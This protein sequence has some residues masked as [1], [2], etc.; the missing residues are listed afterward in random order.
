MI[1]QLINKGFKD[2]DQKIILTGLDLFTSANKNGVGKSAV[3]ESFKLALIGDLPGT[4]YRVEDILEFT[5]REEFS[6]ALLADIGGK[7]YRFERRFV[8]SAPQGDKRPIIVDG[9]SKKFE[10]GS[11]W[12]RNTFGALSLSFD[13]GE[14]LNL[15]DSKKRAW[16]LS[17][18]PE[19]CELSRDALYTLLLARITEAQFGPGLVTSILNRNG[20]E[21]TADLLQGTTKFSPTSVFSDLIISLEQQDYKFLDRIQKLLTDLFALW[22]EGEPPVSNLSALTT[23]LKSRGLE[24]KARLREQEAALSFVTHS[25][26]GEMESQQAVRGLQERL[27]RVHQREQELRF[28]KDTSDYRNQQRLSCQ[29]LMVSTDSAIKECE[30]IL[31]MLDPQALKNQIDGLIHDLQDLDPLESRLENLREAL[32]RQ[33]EP[34]T[35]LEKEN[36]RLQS[37]QQWKARGIRSLQQSASKCPLSIDVPCATDWTLYK[38]K[39]QEGL[40]QESQEQ[41][42][43]QEDL[44]ANRRHLWKIGGEIKVAQ[45][46]L[47][48]ARLAN[49]TIH[50]Q[51][52]QLTHQWMEEKTRKEEVESRLKSQQQ[53]LQ[54]A[55]ANLGNDPCPGPVND[56]SMITTQL[57]QLAEEKSRI[58]AELNEALKYQGK[59]EAAKLWLREN[60]ALKEDIRWVQFLESELGPDGIQE[61]VAERVGRE[62]S[63]EVNRLLQWIQ[64]DLEFTLDLRCKGFLMGWLRDGKMI[65]FSTMNSAH[66]ILFVVPFLT[67]LLNRLARYRKGLGLKTLRALCVEA[68][69]LTVP[70]L[71]ALLK[72]LA[73]MKAE[74]YLD[75]VLV[76]HYMSLG[77]TRLLSGFQEHV[78]LSQ[79]PDAEPLETVLA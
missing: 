76:A 73:R 37:E 15:T 62:I 67:A 70:N 56:D 12:I 9:L 68:E 77:E 35:Q 78:L 6:I 79:T 25:D 61:E 44:K 3:L 13:P 41:I 17:N 43:I 26:F 36:L 38:D 45:K 49:E 69:T 55:Q 24:L 19:T 18:S 32:N 74:G 2:L 31:K 33:S 42:K 54:E 27:D 71:A 64:P 75:N 20:M 34:G 59:L 48:S 16:I 4:A 51:I 11:R 29:K 47:K 8:K 58:Q 14:F 52:S 53:S 72:G 28:L 60:E 66:F 5:S 10:E 23:Y 7:E 40:Q 57:N 22:R 65:P 39:L 63:R 21:F 50:N 46:K 30:D 1:K